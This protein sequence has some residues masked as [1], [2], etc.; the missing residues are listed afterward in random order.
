[1]RVKVLPQ[2]QCRIGGVVVAQMITKA[3]QG[4]QSSL[5]VWFRSGCQV[6]DVKGVKFGASSIS[7]TVEAKRIIYHVL[8]Q[9]QSSPYVDIYERQYAQT[10]RVD[11]IEQ[12]HGQAGQLGDKNSQGRRPEPEHHDDDD[13]RGIMERFDHV[14][15][16]WANFMS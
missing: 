14:T 3:K 16:T 7:S 1:M 9:C 10:H 6:V 12:E 2:T 8:A 4:E 15:H 5:G 13:G 11:K